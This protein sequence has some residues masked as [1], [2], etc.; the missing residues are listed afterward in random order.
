[1]HKRLTAGK[2][3]KKIY[4]KTVCTPLYHCQAL[5]FVLFKELESSMPN[6]YHEDT[7]PLAYDG[8]RLSNKLPKILYGKTLKLYD[9]VKQRR[10]WE[11]KLEKFADVFH[12][13]T[14]IPSS[15]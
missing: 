11:G 2:A 1:M 12:G 9:F 5:S 3:L 10:V 7:V 14:P 15:S 6:F 4:E 8:N 13:Q